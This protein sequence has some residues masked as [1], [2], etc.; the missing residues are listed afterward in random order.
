MTETQLDFHLEIAHVLFIDIVGYS[1]LLINEQGEVLQQLN[2]IVRST[3]QF[4]KA[5]A[6]GE[7]IRLPTGDGMVLVFLHSAEAPVQCA[8]EISDSLRSHPNM[9]LRMGVHSGPVN[10]IT[11]VNDKSNLAG[12]GINVAQR[13]MDCGDAG[14]ILLSKRVAD[15]LA[16]YRQWQSCLHDVGEL[17]V[18]H[19]VRIHVVNLYTDD[20]GNGALPEKFKQE[21]KESVVP[22]TRKGEGSQRSLWIAGILIAAIALLIGLWF[23][24]QRKTPKGPRP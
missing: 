14:H 12:A 10:R 19:G 4:R 13:I 21:T 8:I 23:F 18:K 11:D 15:D 7:L 6:S 24:W 1:K 5:E 17:E 9:Q 20:L 3:S 2:Q 22:S 16:H